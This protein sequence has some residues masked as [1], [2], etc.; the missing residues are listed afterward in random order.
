MGSVQRKL[1][2]PGSADPD[3]N[4]A[5]RT[6]AVRPMYAGR[7]RQRWLFGQRQDLPRLEVLG[8]TSM[9]AAHPG[10]GPARRASLSKGADAVSGSELLLYN[11][12]I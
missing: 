9:S 10:C 3:G 5:L 6:H 2:R 7:P 12:F 11:R 1:P 8:Q 4:G